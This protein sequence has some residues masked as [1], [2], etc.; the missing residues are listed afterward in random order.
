M[1]NELLPCPFCGGKAQI[2]KRKFNFASH[3]PLFT[4]YGYAIFCTKCKCSTE[5]SVS[6]DEAKETWN[7]RVKNAE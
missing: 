6:A 3:E 2:H 4:D 7:R 1:Q 5:Y